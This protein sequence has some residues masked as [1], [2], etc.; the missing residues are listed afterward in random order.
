MIKMFKNFHSYLKFVYEFQILIYHHRKDT[1][2]KINWK[3]STIIG[4]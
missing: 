4:L 3:K 2:P 1:Y